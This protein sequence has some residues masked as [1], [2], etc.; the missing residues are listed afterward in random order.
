MT[1]ANAARRL[2][3]LPLG[4]PLAVHPG[5]RCAG[6]A[7]IL[8]LAAGLAGCE[9]LGF[10]RQAVSG[11]LSLLWQRQDVADLLADPDTPAPLAR[12]LRLSQDLLDWA[13]AEL[14]LDSA[15]QYRSFVDLDREAAVWVVFA[16]EEFS[17]AP[18]QWCYPLVGCLAY[19]GYFD[20]TRAR[21]LQASLAGKDTHI[22][23][24]AAYSTLGWFRD[25]LL[26]TFIDYPDADLAGLLFHELAHGRLFLAGDTA[27]NESYASFVER[28]GAR[29]WLAEHREAGVLAA[30]ELRWRRLDAFQAMLAHWRQAL[31]D[32]YSQPYPDATM[33]LLK[34]ALLDDLLQCYESNADFFDGA[35]DGYFAQPVN[36]ARLMSSGLYFRWRDSFAELFVESGRDWA[37]FHQAAEAWSALPE[38]EREDV[39]RRYRAAWRA[40]QDA[41][42]DQ[43]IAEGRDQQHPQQIQCQALTHHRGDGETASAEHDDVRGSRHR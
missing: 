9:T 20:E 38:A 35:Y 15:G 29:Q 4:R 27:F 16:A 14:A 25:P 32:L 43:H 7:L 18:V 34:K 12:Q 13:E 40:R 17:L 2:G 1:Q 6:I 5:R 37:A 23:A 30:A 26:S 24:V 42:G 36:N 10:Y 8:V 31:A 41:S 22:S 21:R 28:E 11:Q 33:R 19:R 39:L 3:A